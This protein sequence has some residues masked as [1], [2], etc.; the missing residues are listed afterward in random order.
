LHSFVDDIFQKYKST[1]P[2]Y[3]V[4]RLDYPGISIRSVDIETPGAPKN[5]LNTF[6]KKDDIDVSEGL[7]FANRRKV[8]VRFTHLQH[9]DFMYKFQVEN[10]TNDPKVGTVRIFLA[11]KFDERGVNMFFRDQRLLFIELDKFTV[12]LE[13][14]TNSIQR[15]STESS[16]TIP[17][18]RT[19]PEQQANRPTGGAELEEFNFCGC[20]WPQ[21]MLIPKG[22]PQ[23]CAVSCLL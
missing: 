9:T 3:D 7:D 22:T 19:F 8:Y 5:E 4:N 14:K 2:R 18:E 1:L 13:P 10:S 12:T 21:H 17:F 23:G 11:P 20:G 16:L 15:K 6:W